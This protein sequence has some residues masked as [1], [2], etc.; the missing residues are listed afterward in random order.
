VQE[1]DSQTRLI[2]RRFASSG[3]PSSRR[4][5][6]DAAMCACVQ[7]F[8]NSSPPPFS[9]SLILPT[10]KPPAP[11]T[12]PEGTAIPFVPPR[13]VSGMFQGLFQVCFGLLHLCASTSPSLI[14]MWD[15]VSPS[16]KCLVF[17]C[18]F[19]GFSNWDIVSP[20]LICLVFF[21]CFG[22]LFFVLRYSQ[23]IT[24]MYVGYS[25]GRLACMQ[26]DIWTLFGDHGRGIL[27]CIWTFGDGQSFCMQE[28]LLPPAPSSR[29]IVL[30]CTDRASR[31]VDSAFVEHVVGSIGCT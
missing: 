9:V 27:G 11:N 19:F 24:E 23:P 3:G 13:A 7:F 16:L 21:L 1:T 31:G 18:V 28:F 20:S 14:R 15:T 26:H 17:C 6:L 30:V 29:R 4:V 10:W 8:L 5:Y 25:W 2:L 22:F 12:L